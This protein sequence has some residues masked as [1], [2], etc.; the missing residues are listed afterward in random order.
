MKT[1]YVT[2]QGI[3]YVGN[4]ESTR[5]LRGCVGNGAVK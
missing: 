3:P 2:L 5:T 1:T 4:P